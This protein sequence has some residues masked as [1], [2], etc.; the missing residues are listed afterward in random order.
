[1]LL[2]PSIVI[3]P[4]DPATRRLATLARF[5]L[6]GSI[7]SGKQWVSWVAL[8]DCLSILLRAID[9]PEMIGEYL[10]TSP[11]P[12]RNEEMMSDYREAVGRR[13]GIPSPSLFTKVG[14]WLLGS[15]PALAL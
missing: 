5:G 8:A 10:V 2:R 14:A 7:A 9:S 1:V 6:G 3:G 11:N 15:D 13:M 12:I 4:G